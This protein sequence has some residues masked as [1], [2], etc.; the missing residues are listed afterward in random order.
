[1]PWET[2]DFVW[3]RRAVLAWFRTHGRHTLP[4]R[5][6]QDPWAV[7][8]SEL[9]L[10]RTRADL[11]TPVYVRVM[12][13]WPTALE[14]AEADPGAVADALRPLGLAHRN[15]RI[16]AAAAVCA[17]RGVPRTLEG[18]LE[19]PGVGRYSATATLC[20]AYGRHLAVVD[21]SVIRILGR[22]GFGVCKRPRP[23]EDPSVWRAATAL[24]PSRGARE[25]NYAMLDLGALVCRKQP[26][27][28]YCPVR[29]NCPVALTRH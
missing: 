17:E 1:M 3:L 21:P 5:L 15:V 27:C 6:T 23:R 8:L 14:L 16:R 2:K 29:A 12:A 4:W 25:W 20:F 28:A 7:L 13:H 10:Q 26:L 22:L 19:I 24:L 18:L 11:V 9:M